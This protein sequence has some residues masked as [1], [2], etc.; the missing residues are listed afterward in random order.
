MTPAPDGRSS[1]PARRRRPKRS[2]VVIG[3]FLALIV[4]VAGTGVAV[5]ARVGTEAGRQTV[6]MRIWDPV[7]AVANR[8]SIREFE[9]RH[10]SIDVE[11]TVVP[12]ADYFTK[13]RT[14]IAGRA[15]D[16]VFWV[17]SASFQDYAA[18]GDLL[19]VDT[20]LGRS[21]RS[22]WQ[23]SVVDQYSTGGTL[24][25][26]PQLADPGIGV[27]YNA[28]LLEQ[29]G[30]DPASIG[31][32]HWDPTGRDDTLLP[33][34]EKLTRDSS[35]RTADQPGFDSSNI[36]QYGYNAADDLNALY[37]NYLG[38]NGAALQD[39]DRFVFASERGRQAFQYLVDLIDKY[40]VAPSAAD[41]NTN[42][43]FSRDQFTQ[44]RMALLQTGSYN[45]A[46]VQEA[47]RFDWGITG[48]PQGPEGAISVT[49]GVVAAAKSHSTHPAAV[50]TFLRWLGSERGS[51]PIGAQGSASPAVLA[52]QDAYRSYWR[53]K[54]VDVQPLYDVLDNGTV[55][56]PQGARFAAA[57]EAFGPYLETMFLG[58]MPVEESLT[59]AQ[60]AANAAIAGG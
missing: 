44:G 36:V 57:Q 46:T 23:P 32:L 15:V 16:D 35:G 5:A 33:V 40:H 42:G 56:A 4:L 47:A 30:V 45:L 11:L 41:T 54:G 48:M 55:Q 34:L 25:G 37:I 51:R 10:P 3:A 28:Q 39:G 59:R 43:D 38:S 12:Y 53:S 14:D 17:N 1:T 22:A 49:N 18:A 7:V 24:W 9:R 52:A 21:A 60:R 2:S 8:A 50:R 26:V 13:L 58:R 19:D 20:A 29:A 6:T 31:S 27:F